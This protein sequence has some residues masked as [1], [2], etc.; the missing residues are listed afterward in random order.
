MVNRKPLSSAAAI[1]PI[2][3]ASENQKAND[4]DK[5]EFHIFLQYV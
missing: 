1:A 2:T 5:N 4:D 3:A